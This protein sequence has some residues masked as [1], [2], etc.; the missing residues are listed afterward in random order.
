VT[1]DIPDHVRRRAEIQE[2]GHARMAEIMQSRGG[3]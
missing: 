2:Q 1:D 3:C